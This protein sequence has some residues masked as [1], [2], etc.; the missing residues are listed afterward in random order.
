V[1]FDAL[2]AASRRAAV[3]HAVE[4][5]GTIDVALVAH[6]YMPQEEGV[7]LS[8][9]EIARTVDVNLTGTIAL[10]RDL[11]AAFAAQRSGTIAVVSSIAGERGKARNIV[12]AAAKAGLSAYAA[13]LRNALH[14]DGVRV[15]TILPGNTDTPMA[16]GRAVR[17]PSASPQAVA[18]GI[19]RTL[20]GRADVA[21]VPGFWRAVVG[22]IKLI[23]EPLYKRMRW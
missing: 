12:Y 5:L 14:G 15:V 4:R 2:D 18:H 16:R 7:A 13:G 9:D 21:F 10:L 22:A 19:V 6:G 8:D 11:A 1:P 17:G 3:A 20:D 23:P